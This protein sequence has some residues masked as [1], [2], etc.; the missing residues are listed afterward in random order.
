M[1]TVFVCAPVARFRCC[2][3]WLTVKDQLL[4]AAHHPGHGSDE[5]AGGL[6][7][8][9]VVNGR[10]TD[11]PAMVNVRDVRPRAPCIVGCCPYA[12]DYQH[13]RRPWR[14]I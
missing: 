1:S 2:L 3:V 14:S 8:R 5:P 12:P 11:P 4:L 10:L 9:D 7:L 13:P 6:V